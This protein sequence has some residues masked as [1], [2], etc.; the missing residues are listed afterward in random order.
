M[1][2]C[3]MIIEYMERFGSITNREAM[4]ELGIGR[5]AS[6]ICELRKEGYHIT[7]EKE[8]GKDR[9]GKINYYARYKLGGE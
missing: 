7:S 3:E 8:K 4:F 5:L 6:R 1:T 2:Q 9:F